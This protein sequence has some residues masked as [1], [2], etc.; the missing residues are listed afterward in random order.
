MPR[1][2]PPKREDKTDAATEAERACMEG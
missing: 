1:G 2:R